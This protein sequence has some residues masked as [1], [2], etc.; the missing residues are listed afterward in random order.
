MSGRLPEQIDPIRLADDG[1]RL[2]GMFPG[3]RMVRLREQT[4][5]ADQPVSVELN[6]ERN[7]QGVRRMLGIL[8]TTVVIPCRRCLRP[9]ALEIVAQPQILL[10]PAGTNEPEEGESLT[11]AGPLSLV[12][13][14]EEELLLVMPMFPGHAEGECAVAFP[15]TSGG[16][17]ET[18]TKVN[19]FAELRGIKDKKQD[20]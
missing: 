9:F 18:G 16:M 15:V 6:F 5:R 2:L 20:L 11:V 14:V 1:A 10:L 13:L 12:D 19:P 17:P 3:S 4:L 8:R 7:A